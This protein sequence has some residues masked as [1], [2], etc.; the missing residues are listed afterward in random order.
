MAMFNKEGAGKENRPA[1][2]GSLSI[3]AAGVRIAGDIESQGTLKIDGQIDGSVLNARQ[4][5]LGRDGAINGNVSADEVVVG[6][7]IEGSVHAR[8]RLELQSSAAVHGDIETKSI[9]VLEGAKI[10]GVVRMT[11]TRAALGVVEGGARA[12]K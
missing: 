5:M 2:E 11:E 8:T 4:V 3:I 10:N 7:T 1:T 9:V 12:A 6:G